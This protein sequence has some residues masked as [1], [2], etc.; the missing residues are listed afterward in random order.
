MTLDSSKTL[1]GVGALLIVVSPLAAAYAGF[2]GLIGLILLLI[3]F[4]DLANIYKDRR[5]FN[6][7][8][9]GVIIT[10]V[11]VAIAAVLVIVAAF[12]IFSALNI[13][14]SWND[15]SAV[16]NYNWRGFTDWS[17]IAPYIATIVGAL[18]ILIVCIIFAA[19]LLRRSLS[20]L[21]EKSGTHMFA[22]AGLLFLIGA[23]LTIV[24]IG[25]VLLWVAMIL[26]AVSFFQMR[27]PPAQPIP[28][29]TPT[30]L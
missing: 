19:F 11:G 9:Y 12:G 22:T 4:N 25:V 7:A 23:A 28:P 5:I 14:V 24:I 20:T 6:N 30:S 1:G 27:T 13:K 16:R 18:I 29:P 2:L 10:I 3:A 17:T 21:S 8:L 26:L 15:W